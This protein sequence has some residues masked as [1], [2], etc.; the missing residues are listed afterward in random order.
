MGMSQGR[1]APCLAHLQFPLCI[2]NP[3]TSSSSPAP[4]PAHRCTCGCRPQC[5]L[6]VIGAI[7][8]ACSLYRH[9]PPRIA[10]LV[11]SPGTSS[12]LSSLTALASHPPRRQHQPQRNILI[13]F[14]T[15][16]GA[17]SSSF[18][19]SA[20]NIALLVVGGGSASSSSSAPLLAHPPCCSHQPR[21]I[22][23][24]VAGPGT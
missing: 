6:L 5:V 14:L 17:S 12:S 13:D 19:A 3:G 23:F 22:L 2:A 20:P 10:L 11:A 15:G 8:G 9:Q 24:L 1:S 16:S 18:L 7:A 4:V 21:H